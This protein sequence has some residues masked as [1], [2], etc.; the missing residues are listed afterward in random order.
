MI[1]LYQELKDLER[2]KTI[3]VVERQVSRVKIHYVK[4]Q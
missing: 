4:L 1:L 3:E 2:E